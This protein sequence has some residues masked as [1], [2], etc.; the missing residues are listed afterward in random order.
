MKKLCIFLLTLL[1][2][3]GCTTVSPQNN[4]DVTTS[5][6]SP[7]S[8]F[9]ESK[10]SV[11]YQ[12][13]FV[14]Q[15]TWDTYSDTMATIVTSADQLNSLKELNYREPNLNDLDTQDAY[16]YLDKYDESPF[17]DG[18][19]VLI[20]IHVTYHCQPTSYRVES[21]TAD[22]KTIEIELTRMIPYLFS[23]AEGG[24]VV[25]LELYDLD[26]QGQAVNVSIV[27]EQ[28][29]EGVPLPE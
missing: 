1:F 7:S 2:L 21:V 10:T 16:D 22:E 5:V 3:S 4:L 18:R 11:A 9:A 14:Y 27:N 23:D 29:A 15:E 28:L 26:Y 13:S 6:P 8:T 17:S 12:S 20:A 24:W 19:M 25:F